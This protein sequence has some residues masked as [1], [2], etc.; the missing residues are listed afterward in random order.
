VSELPL[1]I[2]NKFGRHRGTEGAK[3]EEL[4]LHENGT[5]PFMQEEF[6]PVARCA[7]L[8][9]RPET[10]WKAGRPKPS[11]FE[12]TGARSRSPAISAIRSGEVDLAA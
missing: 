7:V 11:A 6:T 9:G 8:R 5:A 2:T 3:S 12:I 1:L 4:R 10:N